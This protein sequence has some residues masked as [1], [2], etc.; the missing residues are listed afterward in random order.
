MAQRRYILKHNTNK[1]IITKS[2]L[3]GPFPA[4]LLESF[5]GATGFSI[6][7]PFLVFLV[8]QWGGNALIYGLVGA[9]YSL[10]QLIGSPILGRWSDIYGRK[11]LLFLCQL[12]TV[13]A[14]VLVF[15]AFSLSTSVLLNVNSSLFGNFSVTLPLIFL[16]ISRSLDGL[17]GG[18]ISIANAYVADIST[19][20]DRTKKIGKMAASSNLGYIIGPA[21][22]GLL[23]GTALG[24][25]LPVIFTLSIS[26]IA[27]ILI[28]VS[29]PKSDPIPDGSSPVAANMHKMLGHEH[30]SCI[31]SKPK[32]EM[33]KKELFL[34]PG[35]A[36]LLVI[37]F[38]IMLAFNFFYVAFPVQAATSMQWTVKHTGAFFSVMS[39]FMVV[40]QGPVLSRLSKIWS[41][42][43]FV[44]V[45]SII[46][47][48]GFLT[49]SPAIS[50]LAFI[51]AFLIALG[52]GLMWPS[53]VA[54]LS[55]EA[56]SHQGA[57]QGLAESVGA[58]ASLFGLVLGGLLFTA[59]NGWLFVLAA[60]SVFIVVFLTPLLAK[61]NDKNK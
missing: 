45:G 15:L 40:V 22:A 43:R 24:Y 3:S 36:V 33:S 17:T 1:N 39:L 42:K 38:L 59:I 9:A 51:G 31:R 25:K 11:R 6:V 7:M 29:L 35:I 8:H 26:V 27:T 47:A 34:L 50:W 48:C 2:K 13:I 4:L 30:N 52:N 5:T 16:F 14:W 58:A 49:L 55:K 53:V 54:L 32:I 37:Y 23:G 61:N 20:D 46:L 21:L 28:I 56:D 18:N 44:S 12:G 10:F 41:E 19:G 60:G 57:V